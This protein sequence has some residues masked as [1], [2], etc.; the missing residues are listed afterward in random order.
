MSPTQPVIFSARERPFAASAVALQAVIVNEQEQI[1]LLNN[2][3]RNRGWQVVSG[4]LEAGETILDGAL[5]EVG[6]EVGSAVR[7]R[8]L[9]VLHAQTFH[10]DENV[11]FMI[12][13][14]YLMLYDGGKIV[15]GDD[16][17]GSAFRWWGLKDL[18]DETI[19]FHPST[20]PWMLRR[21]VDF[22]RLW[23]NG[24][25]RPSLQPKL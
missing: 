20:I 18:A 23:Q 14:Y 15:P 19:Q 10:Y 25:E 2:P 8:P 24:L 1:L 12:G 5:R 3:R 13:I 6:E 7:V 21:A 17:V 9:G 11:Q 4:A 16:M 22:Y